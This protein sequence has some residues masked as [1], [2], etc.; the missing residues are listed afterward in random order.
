M[1]VLTSASQHETTR[2]ARRASH[3]FCWISELHDYKTKVVKKTGYPH[4]GVRAIN[5]RIEWVLY[6]HLLYLQMY[7]DIV[8]HLCIAQYA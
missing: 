3:K 4:L 7:I 8:H 6:W 5:D 2:E 1:H